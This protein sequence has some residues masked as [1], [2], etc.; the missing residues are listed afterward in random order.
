[1]FS[2]P[3]SNRVVSLMLTW[4]CNL[5]CTY[6]FEKFK[7]TDRK[8]STDTAQKILVNEFNNFKLHEPEGRLKVEFFGGEPLL[9]FD[10]IREITEWL[11]ENDPGVDYLLS[12][13][14]NGTL[15]DE[16]KKEWFVRNKDRIRIVMSVD[17][18]NNM[19]E[20]NRGEKAGEVPIDFVRKTWPHIH[21]KSTISRAN[22]PHLA[23]GLIS[24][25]QAGH[26]IAPNLAQGEDWKEGDD[27]IYKK[28]LEKLA[29]WHLAHPDVEPMNFFS[30]PFFALLEPHCHKTPVKNCGTGTTMVTYDVDGTAYPCHMFVPITHGKWDIK[31]KLDKINFF[32]DESLIDESCKKCHMLRICKT[33]Y[34]FDLKDRGSIKKRDKRACRMKLAEAQIISDFQINW[35][36]M[37]K[38]RRKLSPIELYALKG[39]IRCHELYN[40]FSF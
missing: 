19:Q 22:L 28:E 33:C 3:E 26:I 6:C 14:T 4:A 18:A 8:M 27:V 24:L 37:Q 29:D 9:Q 11:K 23:E 21:F 2:K 39:A 16:K 7:R 36:M 10:V 35:L 34:G 40:S 12:V 30:Q 20:V 1:M 15:L 5:D 13:T 32:D 17:G 38:Q 31:E 25:L